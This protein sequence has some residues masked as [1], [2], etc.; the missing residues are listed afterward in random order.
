MSID[1]CKT[2]ED[3]E[4]LILGNREKLRGEMSDF[5]RQYLEWEIDEAM[6]EIARLVEGGEL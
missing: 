1:D 2:V 6:E 4:R 3:F 5:D